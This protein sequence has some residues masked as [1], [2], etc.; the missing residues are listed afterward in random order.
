MLP[1]SKAF[2]DNMT[3]GG[4]TQPTPGNEAQPGMLLSSSLILHIH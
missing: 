1:E 3:E 4:E 2:I